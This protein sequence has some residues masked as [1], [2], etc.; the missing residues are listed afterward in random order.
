MIEEVCLLRLEA[1]ISVCNAACA[2]AGKE[3]PSKCALNVKLL[4]V[5]IFVL[6]VGF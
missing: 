6:P 5:L 1:Y 2:N 4:Q 3:A